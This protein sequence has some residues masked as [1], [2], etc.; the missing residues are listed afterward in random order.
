MYG[1]Q[2]LGHW[3]IWTGDN[4]GKKYLFLNAGERYRVV[5]TFV[6]YDGY[7]HSV[8]EEWTFLGFAFLPVDDG[9]SWFVS[10]DGIDEW[11]IRMQCTAEEQGEVVEN[12][13]LYIVAIVGTNGR[14]K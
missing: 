5:R 8:G 11:H 3:S 13:S 9:L 10:L 4:C 14:A 6:D 7:V 12:L 1:P 2:R